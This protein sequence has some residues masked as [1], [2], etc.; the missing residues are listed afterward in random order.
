MGSM[1][2]QAKETLQHLQGEN[3]SDPDVAD[4]AF[5]QTER[6]IE[7][8][9]RDRHRKLIAKIDAALKRLDDATCGFCAETGEPTG[10]KRLKARP[11]ATF[12]VEAQERHERH[13]R[14]FCDD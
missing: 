4:R 3:Q 2:N 5:L 14:V 8:R 7:L 13:E 10:L 6:S 1:H 12:S 11:I 9:A